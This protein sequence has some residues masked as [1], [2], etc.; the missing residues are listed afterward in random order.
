MDVFFCPIA[1]QKCQSYNTKT[2]IRQDIAL[3]AIFE[4]I[5]RSRKRNFAI[6]KNLS[7]TL[8][9]DNTGSKTCSCQKQN[10]AL[11]DTKS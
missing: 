2:G 1:L 4:I 7:S 11:V 6:V 8:T 3:E 10:I 5:C 9:V